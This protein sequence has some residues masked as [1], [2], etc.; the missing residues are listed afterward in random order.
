MIIFQKLIQSKNVYEN[1]FS[2]KDALYKK[3]VVKL[4][5]LIKDDNPIIAYQSSRC[6]YFIIKPRHTNSSRVME[7]RSDLIRSIKI[8]QYIE[9]LLL[10]H[11]RYLKNK[12]K[13]DDNQISCPISLKIASDL[14]SAF[15]VSRRHTSFEILR[16]KD[17][18]DTITL[19]KLLTD[20]DSKNLSA[21]NQENKE[22]P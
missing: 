20:V 1:L 3:L 4:L 21:D 8:M 11:D 10:Y 18:Q 2:L 14:L 22:K 12:L 5:K 15:L 7:Y 17:D 13:K 19:D 16:T 9:R 6:I